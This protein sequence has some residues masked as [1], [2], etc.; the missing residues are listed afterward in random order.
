MSARATLIDAHEVALAGRDPHSLRIGLLVPLSGALGLTGPSAL[1]AAALAATEINSRGGVGGRTVEIAVLDAGRARSAVTSDVETLVDSGLIASFVGLHTSDTLQSIEPVVSGRVPYI[2]TPPHEGG[3]RMPGVF[4]LGESPE[5]QLAPPIDWLVRQ[6]HISSW[7]LVGNDYVWPRAMHSAARALLTAAGA[8]VVLERLVPLG[9]T[10]AI[11]DSLVVEIAESHAEAVILNFAGTELVAINIAL[12]ESGLDRRLVRLSGSLEENGLMAFGGDDT[13][14]LYSSMHSFVTLD[15]ERHRELESRRAFAFGQWA[16]VFH[17]YAE[18]VYD[19]V[20][21][22]AELASRDQL[23]VADLAAVARRALTDAS[24][25]AAP[26]GP[27]LPE[28]HLAVADGP[29]FSVLSSMEI[30]SI[31]ILEK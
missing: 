3:S 6:R 1:D 30:P 19:G 15:S 13:G 2:F 24:W 11:A 18:G 20:H 23:D 25:H 17:A 21:L 31:E 28:V 12:H 10:A 29:Q 14:E 5:E 9:A 7:A 4:C 27:K 26:L 8:T 22:A 16:P